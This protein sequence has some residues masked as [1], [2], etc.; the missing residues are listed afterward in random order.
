MITCIVR[1]EYRNQN[2]LIVCTLSQIM[3]ILMSEIIQ[4]FGQCHPHLTKWLLQNTQKHILQ[5]QKC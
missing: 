5:V 3:Q 4:I 1:D 2:Y